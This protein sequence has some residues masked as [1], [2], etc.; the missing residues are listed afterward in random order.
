MNARGF[1]CAAALLLVSTAATA[2]PA[3]RM[4]EASPKATV[5][6]TVGI[7]DIAVHYHRPAVSK[8]RIWGGLVGY[9]A[10]W[11]A[12]ANESTKISFSTPV[13]V[14]GQSL[15]AGDY[16]LFMIPGPSQ[17]TVIFNKFTGG[18]GAYSYDPSEDAVRVTVT[19]QPTADSQERLAYTFDDPTDKAATLALRWE[20]LR[21]PVK[22]EADTPALVS[23]SIRD[24][25]RGG[26]HWNVD[27][28]AAAAR[29][30]L[31]QG[32]VDEALALATRAMDGRID[33]GTLRT[34]AAV[35]EK[36]GDTKGAAELRERAKALQTEP[37]TVGFVYTFA[38][39][40]QWDEGIAYL[41]NFLSTHPQSWRAYA[42]LGELYASKGDKAKAKEQFD[43][44]M[45]LARDT[46]ERVE[47]Q[48]AINSIEAEG[49]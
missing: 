11:R 36:K 24:E 18:W 14:E 15:P 45:S 23:A 27:A 39:K 21:V 25:L 30:N 7:T 42:A 19:P 40:K 13:K 4:P 41:N 31:R 16:S 32:N 20:K 29:Y 49:T 43:K 37:E 33:T 1:F 44:A 28:L 17:W 47:V 35:L 12:G 8:R 9:G 3:L 46:A 5:S 26:K 2:Q 34:K 10:V 6:Q 48:D 38:Q 22:I